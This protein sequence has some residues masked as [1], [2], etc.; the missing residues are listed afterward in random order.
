[1]AGYAFGFLMMTLICIA[2][3]ILASVIEEK[4]R[5]IFIDDERNPSDVTWI[6]YD[7]YI[8]WVVVRNYNE[9]KDEI[10]KNGIPRYIS[11][12]HDLSDYDDNGREYTGVCCMKF[13]IDHVINTNSKLPKKVYFHTQ[14]PIGEQNMKL[15]YENF[16]KFQKGER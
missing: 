8:E 9:F 2:T 13:L 10:R 5:G 11:F 4:T 3:Y 12:D 15:Y 6:K 1:M 7:R 16:L 14:N